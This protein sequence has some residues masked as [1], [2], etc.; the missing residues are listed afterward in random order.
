MF[1]K[2]PTC[3]Q[4]VCVGLVITL[5]LGL[6]SS[7]LLVRRAD[8]TTCGPNIYCLPRANDTWTM[9]G[10]GVIRWNSVYPTFLVQGYVDIRLY[11]VT[12]LRNPVLVQLNTTNGDGYRSLYL[13]PD[14]QPP[15]F[16]P[17]MNRAANA[18]V[19]KIFRLLITVAGDDITNKEYG[20][21][22]FIQEPPTA[23]KAVTEASPAPSTTSI[24]P[25][26]TLSYPVISTP[27]PAQNPIR[28]GSQSQ[29]ISPGA[30]AGISVGC[31]AVLVAAG[32]YPFCA[33]IVQHL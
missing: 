6:P 8:N 19:I 24:T 12:D 20:P 7:S 1:L 15:I 2:V 29:G 16:A 30:I 14:L 4:V 18:T 25:T 10:V 28:N 23:V 27:V 13:D 33:V 3:N 26:V 5:V 9:S 17:M 32:I 11:D 31:V 22:F 21:L